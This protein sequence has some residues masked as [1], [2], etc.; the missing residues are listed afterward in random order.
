MSRPSRADVVSCTA[1]AMAAFAANS[2]LCR[3]ALR[4]GASDPTTFTVVRLLSG[5]ALVG[6]LVALRRGKKR[7]GGDWIEGFL[8]AL[9]AIAF[10]FAYVRLGVGTAALIL[11]GT[12]QVAMLVWALRSGERPP[13]LE[14]VGLL[15]A[16]AG[17]V[18]LVA[19]G[20]TAPPLGS[21]ALMAVAGIAWGGY[22]LRGRGAADPLADT[23]GNFLRAAPF[24]LAVMCAQWFTQRMAIHGSGRGLLLAAASGAIASGLGYAIWYRALRGLTAARA[25]VVQLSVPVLAAIGGLVFLGER[26]SMRLV[27]AAAMILGGIAV[28]LA[29][30][31]S[32]G[33]RRA[34]N[35]PA[36]SSAAHAGNDSAESP[37][38]GSV[39]PAARSLPISILAYLWASP[40]TLVAM[41]VFLPL[42]WVGGGNARWVSG[43]LEIHGGGVRLFLSRLIPI[44]GGATAMTL[45]HVVIGRDREGLDRTRAHERVHVRQYELLGPLMVPVYLVLSAVLWIRGK[46]YYID[47]PF[48]LAARSHADRT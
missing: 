15:C 9:Y 30:R 10:S 48:E 39:A 27:V 6:A 31:R 11:F 17:L 34:Q 24:A 2:V 20:L 47:H 3:L 14:W 37:A 8:L 42:A 4:S 26:V 33:A 35:D 13:A 12:V 46:H 22:S 41:A 29:A 40:A 18:V 1:F 43:V 21:S 16:L 28:A 23:A 36:G 45:G 44:R 19:P 38:A 5:A 7:A 32:G 25:A